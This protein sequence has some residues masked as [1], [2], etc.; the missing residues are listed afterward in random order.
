MLTDP[1]ADI[2]SQKPPTRA[3]EELNVIARRLLLPT[4]VDLGLAPASNAVTAAAIP[5][6]VTDHFA[7]VRAQM[8]NNGYGGV[9]H[10]I[11]LNRLSKTLYYQVYALRSRHYPQRMTAED[12]PGSV[13]SYY[14]A[15]TITV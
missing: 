11:H 4:L 2:P 12:N 14:G 7:I 13:S 10:G 5:P 15:K 9:G 8:K 6:D 1:H 3:A